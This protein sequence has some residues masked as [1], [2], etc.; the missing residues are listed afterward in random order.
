MKPK[1]AFSKKGGL[2]KNVGILAG[3][4]AMAQLITFVAT[5]YLT[6][7]YLPEDFGLLSLL[8]SIVSLLAPISSMRYNKAI[9][10]AVDK[11]ELKSLLHL[12][13]GINISLFAVLGIIAILLWVFGGML[14]IEN[15]KNLLWLLPLAVLLFGFTTIF[16]SYNEKM[17]RFK[18]TSSVAF[19]EALSK[20]TLQYFL[21]T[22]LPKIGLLIG[23]IG[24]LVINFCIYLGS[25]SRK[26]DKDTKVGS[27]DLKAVA[28]KYDKFPKYFTWSNI[29]DSAA[30]NI[31]AYTFPIF[32]TL[33]ALGNFSIAF[34]IVRLPAM[35]IGMATRRVY[36][37]KAADL[38]GND[39][40]AFF[41]LY[42]KS[43]KT[44]FLIAVV[45]VVLIAFFIPYIFDFFFNANWAPSIP[46]AQLILVYV[47]VNFIN[48][49]A[50]ENMLIF[51]LQKAFLAAEV[52]W[53]L[54]SLGLIYVAYLFGDALLAVGLY[55]VGGVIME[56][57]V[58]TIQYQAGKN[59]RS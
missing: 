54:L 46:Y 26:R 40:E 59:L 58:F 32:F 43:T 8:T 41:K 37:P 19:T 21:H 16:Q 15:Y 39:K 30:Q 7:I 36:Y 31:C 9:A 27:S 6:R 56:L 42:K 53:L 52:I 49:L 22:I 5:I 25:Y 14:G 24:A 4:T 28:R 47:F 51:G 12:S 57:M 13:G 38:F 48:S 44:L 34:K 10:L 3:G 45:P 35:L 2:A 50:H 55:V 1:K 11:K 17:A 29:I 33:D 23:Y 18:L 20:S